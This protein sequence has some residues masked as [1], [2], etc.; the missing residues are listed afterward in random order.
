LIKKKIVFGKFTANVQHIKDQPV[1]QKK[2]YLAKLEERKVHK[3]RQ[4]YIT[5]TMPCCRKS[6]SQ[7][8][9]HL[10]KGKRLPV[11][12]VS[13]HEHKY[14]EIFVTQFCPLW[15]QDVFSQ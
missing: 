5:N 14:A 6:L 13:P 1:L 2:Y 10:Q 15:P 3:Y 12:K 8:S 9:I 7:I 4:T 11:V